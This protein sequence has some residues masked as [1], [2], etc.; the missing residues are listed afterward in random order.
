MAIWTWA[1]PRLWP[2]E[3][4]E[5]EIPGGRE[6]ISQPSSE[7]GHIPSISSLFLCSS[8][9]RCGSHLLFSG[10]AN[11]CFANPPWRGKIIPTRQRLNKVKEWLGLCG[12]GKTIVAGEKPQHRAPAWSIPSL[13]E[14]GR[15]AGVAG[16]GHFPF[17][18]NGKLS[19]TQKSPRQGFL[20][21]LF[22]L[23]L[24]LQVAWCCRINPL[25]SLCLSFSLCVMG[26]IIFTHLHKAVWGL[27]M[28][29]L[30]KSW[31]WRLSVTL[32]LSLE[33]PHKPAW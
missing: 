29:G 3:Q 27:W 17:E 33:T 32:L 19:L 24:A 7:L 20:L 15:L 31:K 6:A 18:E 11:R 5:K 26:I 9:Y 21:G 8:S 28:E 22:A 4:G 13:V 10:R 1:D 2:E 30:Y 16:D 25:S 12:T 14:A 23:S